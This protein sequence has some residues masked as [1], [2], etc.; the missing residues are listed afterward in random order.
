MAIEGALAMTLSALVRPGT[1]GLAPWIEARTPDSRGSPT[2]LPPALPSD[3][4]PALSITLSYKK[5]R[6]P[7]RPSL[8]NT[9]LR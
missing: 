6:S 3:E 4:F 1:A 7:K 8:S 5:T 2:R 9:N